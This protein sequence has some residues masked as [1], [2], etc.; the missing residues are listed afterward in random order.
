MASEMKQSF[1]YN[2]KHEYVLEFQLKWII[3]LRQAYAVLISSIKYRLNVPYMTC[4]I[5]LTL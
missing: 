4:E 2:Y 1:N 3:V 5:D